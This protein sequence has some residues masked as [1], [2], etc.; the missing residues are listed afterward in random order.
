MRKTQAKMTKRP[1]KQKK[2]NAYKA[3]TDANIDTCHVKENEQIC[4][5]VSNKLKKLTRIKTPRQRHFRTH[6]ERV[7]LARSTPQKAKSIKDGP[8]YN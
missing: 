7:N 8:M 6:N 2:I 4:G 1:H 3:S 5:E